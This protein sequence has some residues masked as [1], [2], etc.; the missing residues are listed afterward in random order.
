MHERVGAA[1]LFV[2]PYDHLIRGINKEEF[3]GNIAGIELIQHLHK[4]IEKLAAARIYDNGRTADFAMGL[5]AQIDELWNKDR[6]QIIYTEKAQI[7][8]IPRSKRLAAA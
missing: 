6:R 7:F 1:C 5:T 4:R 2:A 3:I 8:H